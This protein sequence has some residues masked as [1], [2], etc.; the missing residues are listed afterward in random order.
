MNKLNHQG[1]FVNDNQWSSRCNQHL[2]NNR[3]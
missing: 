3:N 1:I 2:D